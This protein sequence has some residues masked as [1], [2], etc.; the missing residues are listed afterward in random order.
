MAKIK[1]TNEMEDLLKV[2]LEK[3]KAMEVLYDHQMWRST[4][5]NSYYSCYD[6][7]KVA[8]KDKGIKTATHEGVQSLITGKFVR[9]N[10]MPNDSAKQFNK[11]MDYR[12][13]ADYTPNAVVDQDFAN[14]ACRYQISLQ[15]NILNHLTTKFESTLFDDFAI[16]LVNFE[17][18]INNKTI[19][20]K[21]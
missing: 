6:L 12:H 3:F 11:L 21:I 15:K 18:K 16:L 20:P 13:I 9:N 10:E 4:V 2:S 17:N 19:K 14:M 7:I 8:L 1:I 5:T